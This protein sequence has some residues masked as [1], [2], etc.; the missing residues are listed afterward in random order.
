MN[1]GKTI[2]AQILD[3]LPYYEFNKC[4]KRYKG[5][6]KVKNFTCLNQFIALAFAQLTY[7][8]SLRDIEA[9]LW[10][11]RSKL[12]HIG[13]RGRVCRNTLAHANEQ[14]DWQIYGDFAQVLIGI[15]RNLYA[16]DEFG[17]ELKEMV[18]A[19]DS[20]T[21]DLC[22]ELFPWAQFRKTKSAI[23]IHTLLDLRGN[24]P[25]FISITKGNVHDVTILDILTIEA[26]SYYILDRGYH[27]F[28]RLHNIHS[29]Q[30]FFITR[31]KTN[32]QTRRLYSF[33]VDKNSGVISDHI[34]VFANYYASKDYP[35]K[36]R[37]VR[38]YDKAA[39]RR[40]VFLTNNFP[41]PADTIAKL[42]K[43][44]WQIELF[45][46]WI[47]QHLRIKAFYGNSENAVKTQ[48]WIAV[49]V[50]VL[51]AIIKKRLKIEAGLYSILQVLSITLFEK[52]PLSQVLTD[53]NLQEKVDDFINQ[54]KLFD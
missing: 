6:Y 44:R 36:L 54:L 17:V 4:V 20:T 51:V 37:R 50:Y 27:D 39:D 22:L 8:E 21:V 9:C 7:R 15:A 46:K 48:I 34:V 24:I 35:D 53:V 31:A 49:S 25:V 23:K 42:F 40:F 5:N 13:I 38:F 28:A 41:L 29:A 43:C 10:A 1:A 52:I 26:G 18:Y 16:D 33:P 11:T 14:R 12:Y 30:A 3:F 47:K 45:F 19:F 2:F 32:T